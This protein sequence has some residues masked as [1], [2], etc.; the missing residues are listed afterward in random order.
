[1]YTLVN[2]SLFGYF[3]GKI[4][5]SVSM[6]SYTLCKVGV[7]ATTLRILMMLETSD[8]GEVSS[9]FV[10]VLIVSEN[11]DHYWVE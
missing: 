1:M 8:G 2:F 10:T 3:T 6:E 4:V 11:R 7:L 9:Y 5:A